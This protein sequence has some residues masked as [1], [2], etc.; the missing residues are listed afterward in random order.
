MLTNG[1]AQTA[2]QITNSIKLD[3][4]SQGTRIEAIEQTVDQTVLKANQNTNCIQSLQEQ[5][6]TALSTID[7]LENQSRCY[8]F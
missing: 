7:D 6:D 4:Q 1:L 5:L 3:L 8:N 2:A